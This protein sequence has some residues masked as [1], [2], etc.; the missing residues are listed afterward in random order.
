MI[1]PEFG[2]D[3]GGNKVM[4]YGNNFHP[5]QDYRDDPQMPNMNHS[6]A[7]FEGLGMVP[8]TVINSTK[9]YCY[10]PPNYILDKVVLEMS[11]NAQQFTNDENVYYYY[12]PPQVF[13]ADPLE[14]SIAG[15]TEVIVYGDRFDLSKEMQC[16]FGDVTVEGKILSKERV[17]CVSPPQTEPGD[18]PLVVHYKHDKYDSETMWFRYF[19]TPVVA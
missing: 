12:R 8:L 2:P 18:Y 4:L 15:G 3:A 14:G 17:R 10:A 13:E 19:E 6:V 1:D 11:L 5:F 16:K 9:A 7:Q